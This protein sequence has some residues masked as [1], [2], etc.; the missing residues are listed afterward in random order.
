MNEKQ[1]Q[2]LFTVQMQFLFN[3]YH[4]SVLFTLL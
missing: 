3:H 2:I 1:N 4:I